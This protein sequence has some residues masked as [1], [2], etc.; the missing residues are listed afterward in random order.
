MIAVQNSVRG[1][2][3]TEGRTSRLP[4]LPFP[5][6]ESE[7]V[8][9]NDNP[10]RIVILS[11]QRESKGLSSRSLRLDPSPSSLPR[12]LAFLIANLELE[13]CA[14]TR[15]QTTAAKSN[16]KYFAIFCPG[17]RRVH[18][19]PI[20]PMAHGSRTARVLI[21]TLGISENELSC[22]K[23]R[24]KQILIGTKSRFPSIPAHAFS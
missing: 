3:L 24:G 15:K 19:A 4:T 2:Q 13:F 21:G 11:D 1:K 12:L 14:S 9:A 20:P 6:R 23:E 18:P 5:Q 17:A 8:I 7:F 16:R 10:T 22:T